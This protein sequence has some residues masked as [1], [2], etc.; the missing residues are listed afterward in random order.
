MADGFGIDELEAR[1][2]AL[3]DTGVTFEM[4]KL[5]KEA[6]EVLKYMSKMWDAIV[7]GDKPTLK[8][9]N[10]LKKIALLYIQSSKASTKDTRNYINTQ[11]QQLIMRLEKLDKNRFM[12]SFNANL[13]NQVN[14]GVINPN[15]KGT[16][17]NLLAKLIDKAYTSPV[18]G[19]VN[20]VADKLLTF[21]GVDRDTRKTRMRQFREDL[22]EGLARSKFF[23]GAIMDLIKLGTLFV[24]S[25]LKDKGTVGKILAVALVAAAPVIGAVI[26]GAVAT[27]FVT[28]IM[29]VGGF[30]GSLFFAPVRWLGRTLFSWMGRILAAI[31]TS[32]AL[33]GL[34]GGLASLGIG[35]GG[36]AIKAVSNAGAVLA[37]GATGFAAE[38]ML[39]SSLVRNVAPNA[40]NKAA[41]SGIMGAL[42]GILGFTTKVLPWVLR[43]GKLFNVVGWI[44]LGIEAIVGIVKW[45]KNR[46]GDKGRGI[47][48]G[49]NI[50]I[51]GVSSQRSNENSMSQNSEGSGTLAGHRITSQFGYR[52]DPFTKKRSFH[53]GVDLDYKQGEAVTALMGGRVISSQWQD[54]FGN[55]VRVQDKNGRIHVYGHLDSLGVRAGQQITR[56]QYLGAAGSTG[57]SE[58]PHVHYGV[59]T[60]TSWAN[61]SY[62]D[63]I[64]Y[65]AAYEPGALKGGKKLKY[66]DASMQK[67]AE[68]L[69]SQG[70][71]KGWFG[72]KK[73]AY[74]EL[75]KKYIWEYANAIAGRDMSKEEDVH[76][77]EKGRVALKASKS[78]LAKEY[79]RKR[80]AE[81]VKEAKERAVATATSI[82]V[83]SA[84]PAEEI[85][86]VTA[87]ATEQARAQWGQ[88]NKKFK[89]EAKNEE[90]IIPPDK[91]PII[92]FTGTE[93]CSK[94]L[95]NVV[96]AQ[97]Q[98]FIQR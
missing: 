18:V 33:G 79:A 14:Q 23:G 75:E 81:D 9:L 47:S 42:R 93:Y 82:A 43:L 41:Q 1:I 38:A 94:V 36:R 17:D 77:I 30:L 61:S 32:K 28:G 48:D 35:A 12:H 16:E 44:W 22:V 39:A 4:E 87:S 21:L 40:A 72:S 13:S 25:W 8:E 73:Q 52:S 92:D 51:S 69:D 97:Q 45:W 62:V 71:D 56:G 7:K 55:T 76:N 78:D 67:V 10:E 91:Q 70:K 96:N 66:K 3:R 5:N 57:R 46:K 20:S 64:A 34:R 54:G 63:P 68:Y 26:A 98:T 88:I 65:L 29:K 27:A 80:I 15:K 89:D 31:W 84:G 85:K 24:A 19:A 58:G 2:D 95:Q 11:F 90:T 59:A 50:G 49:D 6:Q 53:S 37:P 86:D 74:D 83:G 60:D